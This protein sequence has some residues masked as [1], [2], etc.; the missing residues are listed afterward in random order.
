MFSSR[1]NRICAKPP[2]IIDLT[3]DEEE[4]VRS[5]RNM[6]FDQ[7]DD[8]RIDD[9]LN[10]LSATIQ[11]IRNLADKEKVR[12]TIQSI[13]NEIEI[14]F[15]PLTALQSALVEEAPERNLASLVRSSAHKEEAPGQ[16]ITTCH[17]LPKPPNPKVIPCNDMI[18]NVIKDDKDTEM[19]MSVSSTGKHGEGSG[20]IY[21]TPNPT[22]VT[23]SPLIAFQVQLASQGKSSSLKEEAPERNLAS[24]SQTLAHKE[25][26]P[27]RNTAKCQ[28]QANPQNRTISLQNEMILNVIKGVKACCKDTEMLMLVSSTG[29]HGEGS[30]GVYQTPKPT[31][32]AKLIETIYPYVNLLLDDY[33][34]LKCK[35]VSMMDAGAGMHIPGVLF[36]ALGGYSL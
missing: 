33:P 28:S 34:H 35:P 13:R 9:D 19:L 22:H 27:E 26:A 30:G 36:V 1:E 4:L 25:E 6:R 20:G 18:L 3:E 11:S 2:I 5:T 17:S 10:T 32:I 29:K 15:P 16:N 12:A 8:D 31:H 24:L 21:Q 14:A 7:S 23:N